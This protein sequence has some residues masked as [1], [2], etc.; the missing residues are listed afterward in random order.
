MFSIRIM[1]A[2]RTM[3]DF[4][5]LTTIE[6]A[7]LLRAERVPVLLLPVG[8]VEPHGPHAPLGTDV[9]LA[10]EVCERTARA[11]T[12]DAAVRALVLPPVP[13]G[14]TR[15]GAAFR[16]A[17]SVSA[18]ALTAFVV[19]I[20]GSL[21]QDGFGRIAIVNC[22]FEPEHVTALRA[23]EAQ[24]GGGVRLFDLTRRALASRLTDEFQRGSCHA[25]S[26]ETSLVLSARPELIDRGAAADLPA[27]EVDMPAAM[28]A[29]QADFLAM[30]MDQAY[31]GAPA[32]ATAKEGDRTYAVLVEM[33]TEL[34]RELA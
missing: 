30:G 5:E 19:G 33:L 29:G 4:T 8:T 21:A 9:L 13:Y 23:V 22:H 20:C 11:L 12:H 17:V 26:Y 34:I 2:G 15:Y 3:I 1:A 10:T 14:V 31:C 24:L 27:L 18:D 28:A 7:A 6:A 16:G 32:D 25:G